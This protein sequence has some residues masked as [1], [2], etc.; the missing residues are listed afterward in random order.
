MEIMEFRMNP[1]FEREIKREIKREVQHR[2]TRVY[3]HHGG[4]PVAEVKR[5]LER[6]GITEPQLSQLS[7]A[8][9]E[10]REPKVQ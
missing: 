8:I 3:K 6:E 10:G 4:H 7:T 2:L 1:N 5:A 9:S